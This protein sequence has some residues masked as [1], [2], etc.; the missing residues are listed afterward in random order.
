MRLK[1]PNLL[2]EHTVLINHA[3]DYIDEHI[4]GELSLQD[5]ASAAAVSP[6]YFHRMFK[7]IVQETVGE[8][9]VRRRLETAVHYLLFWDWMTLTDI[10]SQSGFS[11]LSSF[12]RS[13]KAH[14]GMSPTLYIKEHRSI[15]SNICQI[16]N[17]VCERYFSKC[18]YNDGHRTSYTY[19]MR[20]AIREIK[21]VQVIYYRHYG[22]GN[23][24]TRSADNFAKLSKLAS[25][26]GLWRSDTV[27]VGIPR[28]PWYGGHPGN[29]RYDACLTL[30]PDSPLP[31]DGS[32][33]CSI[34][35][36][37]YAV[38]RFE[39]PEKM[40]RELMSICLRHWLP[41]SGYAF[42]IRP[43]LMIHYN[44]PHTDPDQKMIVDFCLPVRTKP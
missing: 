33:M 16:D 8:Y 18:E 38:I 4:A 39:E 25:S 30:R 9:I 3:V 17:S 43:T 22:G 23:E 35:G 6:H 7:S 19:S 26:R 12:S 2:H 20:M 14:Y 11:S 24:I 42:D 13:F 1:N 41:G 37:T 31:Q 40:V 21:P 27:L 44:N 5:I 28:S 32:S 15:K 36:G 29:V 10:A 34:A